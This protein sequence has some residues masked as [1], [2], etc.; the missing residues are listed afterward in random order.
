MGESAAAGPGATSR[1]LQWLPLGGLGLAWLLGTS[2]W[3]LVRSP[4]GA[5]VAAVGLLFWLA[6]RSWTRLLLR[7]AAREPAAVGAAVV[8]QA[9]RRP[10]RRIAPCT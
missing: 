4:V 1:L 9:S 3:D 7:A 10:R 8:I 6:G 2:P 5:V